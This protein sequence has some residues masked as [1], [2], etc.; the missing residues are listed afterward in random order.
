M[1]ELAV[2]SV[3]ELRSG[4]RISFAI[5]YRLEGTVWFDVGS[6]GRVAVGFGPAQGTWIL[7][8]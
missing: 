2:Q 7:P 5:P 1:R 3:G 8:T 6:L 4:R